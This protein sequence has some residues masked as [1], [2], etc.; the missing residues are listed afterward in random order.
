MGR[1]II[2]SDHGGAAETVLLGEGLA[3]GGRVVPGDTIALADAI[4][5]A[6]RLGPEAWQEMG[7]RGRANAESNFSVRLMCRRT[8]DVYRE[9]KGQ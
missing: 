9:I 8:L 6:L 7:A 1:P 2:A 5:E 4:E 3:T